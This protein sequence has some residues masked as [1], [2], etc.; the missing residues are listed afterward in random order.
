MKHFVSEVIF[1][2]PLVV[3]VRLNTLGDRVGRQCAARLL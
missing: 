1:A 3:F 2:I